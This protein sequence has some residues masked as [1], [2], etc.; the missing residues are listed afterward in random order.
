MAGSR[1]SAEAVRTYLAPLQ[2]ALSCLS[3]AVARVGGYH[4]REDPQTL[5]VNNG[6][7]VPLGRSPS[8]VFLRMRHTYRIVRT[9]IGDQWI[10]RPLSYIY[11][12]RDESDREV[13]AYHW[14]P[15]ESP[16]VVFPHLHMGFGVLFRGEGLWR[17]HMPTGHQ[18]LMTVLRLTIRD[19][20]VQ[21]TRADWSDVL[22][23]SQPDYEEATLL[24]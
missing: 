21:P 15:D 14:H 7:P 1:T 24:I 18:T 17:K 3:D 5:I 8:P 13:F 6:Q 2:R 19:F 16:D 10:V 4:P 22:D 11:S 12:V 9:P 20:G 23:T